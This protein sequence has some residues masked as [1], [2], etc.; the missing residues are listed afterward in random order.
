[1]ADPKTVGTGPTRQRDARERDALSL[2]QRRDVSALDAGGICGGALFE[3]RSS[4]GEVAI[5]LYGRLDLSSAKRI[6]EEQ[7]LPAMRDAFEVCL[8]VTGLT[9]APPE[10][11]SLFLERRR[12]ALGAGQRLAIRISPAQAPEFCPN[13][14]QPSERP[15]RR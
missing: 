11:V 8:D 5:R 3:K 13:S 1:M 4:P 9:E 2:G 12:Y 7:L 15:V 6:D 14:H 10:A